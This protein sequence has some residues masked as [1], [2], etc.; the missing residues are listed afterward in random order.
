MAALTLPLLAECRLPEVSADALS[1]LS[2]SQLL[3]AGHYLRAEQILTPL[4]KDRPDDGQIAWML[5]R[6]KAATGKLDEAMTLAE[7]ALV[8]D[9]S[10]AEY[11]VQA[12]A[13]A[14]RLAEKAS[15]L[16]RLGYVRRAKQELDTAASLDEKNVDSQWGLMMFYYAAPS[17]IGGDKAKAQ[18]LGQQLAVTVPDLGRY[19]QGRLAIEMKEPE[20][21]ETFYKQAVA[22]NPLLFDNLAALAMYYIRVRPDQAKAERW[23]C[24]AVHADPSRADA[25]ALLARVYSMC[26]CWTE[27]T[28]VAERAEITDGENL[29]PYYAI[30]ETAI[31][32]GEQTEM[33]VGYLRKYLGQTIEG[34]QPN[35]ASARMHLGTGLSRLGDVAGARQELETAIQ[36]DSTLDAA[37]SELKRISAAEKAE[38][39]R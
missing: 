30:A 22:E 23:A 19:Y 7:T 38:R 11:H 8:S 34:S 24:Q 6:A 37:K 10:N 28:A 12:A 2:P 33:A 21:A 25:W 16:K 1:H 36:L 9:A 32:R 27:A 39:T 18:Q 4:L 17:L 31:E 20:K 26:G 15:L 3:E 29:V 5:S 14:G 35:E 13:V